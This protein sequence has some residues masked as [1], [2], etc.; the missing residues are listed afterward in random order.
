MKRIILSIL[1]V[2][3]L[4]CMLA[5]S[6][7]AAA[8]DEFGEVEI[9]TGISEKSSFGDDGK[10]STYTSK[11]VMFDG[12]EYHTYPSY[13][14]FSN[15]K[16]PSLS[17]SE[18]NTASGY[19]YEKN[20][21]VRV[22]VPNGVT[23]TNK[24]FQSATGLV[25]VH[26]PDGY[27]TIGQD[28]FHGCSNLV[29]INIPASCTQTGAWSLTGCS[30]LTTVTFE[31]TSFKTLGDRTF[32]GCTSLESIVLPEGLVTIS[33]RAFYNCNKLSSINIPST[34]T[35]I[36]SQ[37]FQL[38]KFTEVIIPAGVTSLPSKAF[39]YCALNTVTLPKTLTSI[40]SNTFLGCGVKD[41]TYTGSEN[42]EIV[43]AIK[44]AASKATI[45]YANHCE[46]Y[47]SGNH[48]VGE[49][50]YV[51]ASYLESSYDEG[52]CTNCGQKSTLATYD[53]IM[54]FA[55]YSAKINGDKICIGYTINKEMLSVY[56]AKTEKTLSFGVTAA[57]VSE[58]TEKYEPVN[59]DLTP[60]NDKTVVADVNRDYAGF[61]FIISGFTSAYYEKL[62]VMCAYVYDGEDVYYVS[63]ACNT[64]ATPFTFSSVAK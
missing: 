62:L 39:D 14:I 8:T 64:Y 34:V 7:S 23:S 3:V 24:I 21:V 10:A 63:D 25:Y 56:E 31:G 32:E 26:L 59:N 18:L 49:S 22:E 42:D 19:T 37:A 29:S 2:S 54:V 36:K 9:L 12:E 15:S 61:D 44:S 43:T 5:I 53:P 45:T 48:S 27:L 58:G 47:F 17:F 57:V 11:V 51:F 16:T 13:Y 30:K 40:D 1:I 60:I 6:A 46:V 55:G 20:S 41:V 38:C 52:A 50:K 33:S 35:T 4:F 28:G